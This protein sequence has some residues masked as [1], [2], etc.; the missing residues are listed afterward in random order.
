MINKKCFLNIK[1]YYDVSDFCN[2]DQFKIRFWFNDGLHHIYI[3]L[4]QFSCLYCDSKVE[5]MGLASVSYT[6]TS[7]MFGAVF[8]IL[9]INSF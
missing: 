6:S 1:L 4:H 5:I 2:F 3:P 8:I 7:Y 9:G